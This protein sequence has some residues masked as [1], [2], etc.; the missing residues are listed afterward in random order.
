MS[1]IALQ[2]LYFVVL[3]FG[4]VLLLLPENL[5][6]TSHVRF[7]FSGAVSACALLLVAKLKISRVHI[8]LSLFMLWQIG[9]YLISD[10]QASAFWN[11]VF[12]LSALFVCFVVSQLDY[13]ES[14]VVAALGALVVS[15]LVISVI[16]LLQAYSDVSLPYVSLAFPGSSFSNRNFASN[17]ISLSL[18]LLLMLAYMSSV[19]LI[20]IFAT[21]VLIASIAFLA[22]A[23]TR[24]VILSLVISIAFFIWMYWS[25]KEKIA[26]EKWF[27]DWNGISVA[28]VSS[29]T[30]LLVSV[31][32]LV[33]VY[34]PVKKELTLTP[35]NSIQ[36]RIDAWESS[37]KGIL[38]SPILGHGMGSYRA[39]AY[40][41]LSGED[42]RRT[43]NEDK[44]M[45]HAHNQYI[46]IWLENGL[47]GLLLFLS[48]I[49][50]SFKQL[51]R[52]PSIVG[53]LLGAGIA[54]SLI[55]GFF[56]F[57]LYYG[58]TSSL[59]FIYLGLMM[60][61]T[62]EEEG[63]LFDGSLLKSNLIRLF[64]V[65]LMALCVGVSYAGLK[66]GE[67]LGAVYHSGMDR[68]NCEALSAYQEHVEGFWLS[69]YKA[70]IVYV[71]ALNR[72]GVYNA[73]T[74][75]QV[76]EL[77]KRD[78]T[79]VRGALYL[80]KIEIAEGRLEQAQGRLFSLVS[81][82]QELVEP[83]LY[84]ADI[85]MQQGEVDNAKAFLEASKSN[86]AKKPMIEFYERKLFGG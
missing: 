29:K 32:T 68:I 2:V 14:L 47:I 18:P 83:W 63:L 26:N 44:Q 76:L 31:F 84:L 59:F 13:S 24:G 6:Q 25:L 10:M 79:F 22:S 11:M 9:S 21:V 51:L 53:L 74:Y 49:Y 43:T 17:A 23:K 39:V 42:L 60:V 55:H 80:A 7:I 77:L 61:I 38:E 72:C 45:V 30:I 36:Y 64:L 52:K 71:S 69:E 67:R 8:F 86:G 57:P 58:G 62:R 15:A 54:T 48:I 12:W 16:G 20:R 33:W 78:P 28:S 66:H 5:Y 56:S 4:A 3:L 37:A 1:R 70:K 73:E 35:D 19:F 65:L 81:H 85:A 41:Y 75:Q 34:A 27:S 82:H 50:V 40:Q 46:E